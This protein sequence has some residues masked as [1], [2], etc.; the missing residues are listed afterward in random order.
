L[1]K[2][3]PQPSVEGPDIMSGTRSFTGGRLFWAVRK[4]Y[5]TV[6]ALVKY[7]KAQKHPPELI[8]FVDFVSEKNQIINNS[9]RIKSLDKT[10]LK[11][12]KSQ[13]PFFKRLLFRN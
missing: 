7:H 6:K 10:I 13:E 9:P 11:Q 4:R 2:I 5:Y 8:L 3:I 1:P 12:K